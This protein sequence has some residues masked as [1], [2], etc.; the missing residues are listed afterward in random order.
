MGEPIAGH[1]A[2]AGHPVVVVDPAAAD[3]PVTG[4]PEVTVAGRPVE[5]PGRCPVVL[6]VVAT[7]EQVREVVAGDDGLLQAGVPTTVL[8]CST[9]DPGTVRHLAARAAESGSTLLD[10]ALIGGLRGAH[11]GELTVLAGGDPAALDA[12]R[13]E[14]SPFSRAVHH[15]GPVGAG[16]VAK[17]ASNLVH[18][19]QVVA[20]TEAFRLVEAAG[21]SVPAVRAALQDGPADSRALREM[22]QMRFTWWRKDLAGWT[23][24]AEESGAAHPVGDLCAVLMPDVTVDGTAALLRSEPSMGLDW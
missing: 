12:V 11:A 21:L 7:D 1:L 22:E 10:A 14:L 24:L 16:Q 5:L 18:W 9:V 19:A 15:L 13:P 3:R 6:V 2:A 17:G 8:V 4:R 23:A 20:I